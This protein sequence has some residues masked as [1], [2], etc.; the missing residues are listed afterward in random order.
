MSRRWKIITIYVVCLLGTVMTFPNFLNK[1]DLFFLPEWMHSKMRL[2]LDLQGGSYLQLEIDMKGALNDRLVSQVNEVRSLLRQKKIAFQ[3]LTSALEE[4]T[5]KVKFDLRDLKDV[6]AAEKELKSLQ[7]MVISINGLHVTLTMNAQEI[8][9]LKRSIVDQSISIIE[10]RVDQVGT[11]EPEVTSQGTD[12]IVVQLP[13]L[14]DPERV[15]ALINKTAKLTFHLVEGMVGASDIEAGFKAPPGTKLVPNDER[16]VTDDPSIYF[17]VSKQALLTGDSLVDAKQS[18]DTQH[19]KVIVSFQFD[20]AGGRKFAELT[21]EN[22]GRQFAMVLDNKVISAPN[23]NEPITGG[24]GMISGNFTIQSA[25]DLAVLMRAGALPANLTVLEEKTIGP[26]LGSDSINAGKKA[27]IYSIAAVAILMMVLYSVFGI[28][29]NIALIFN[30]IFLIAALSF[31]EATL[32]LPGIA[33]IALTIGMAVDANVLIFE[34]IKEELRNGKQAMEALE[35][36]F[37]R[38]VSTIIDSNVTT[39]IGAV[40]LF[41]FGSGPIRGFAVTLCVGIGISMFTAILLTR[42]IA[43]KW[44]AFR[45]SKDI[46]I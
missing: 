36:G 29:A 31:L 24:H 46:L 17:I 27:T 8:F 38:A 13:G 23:I 25:N 41:W 1:E 45:K 9:R 16:D 15:K 4:E 37:D 33:G 34:R 11:T 7:D 30:V 28:I 22:V 42:L 19:N 40:L 12:R 32:T 14:D 5:P 21:R 20:P 39:V 35:L 6:D 43:E 2:G 10:R 18:F 26:S 44:I 3:N